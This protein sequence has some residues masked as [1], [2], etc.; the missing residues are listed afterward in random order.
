MG[1][2][3]RVNRLSNGVQCHLNRLNKSPITPDEADIFIDFM[4][5]LPEINKEPIYIRNR[6]GVLIEIVSKKGNSRK[7]KIDYFKKTVYFDGNRI[8]KKKQK[9]FD[10]FWS[11]KDVSDHGLQLKIWN[12]VQ[13]NSFCC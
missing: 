4:D 12:N 9:V 3:M 2:E 13:F 6:K 5:S 8:G 10:A 11:F 1:I 7:R